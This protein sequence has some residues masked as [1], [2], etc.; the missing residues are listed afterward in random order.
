MQYEEE[1]QSCA[2]CASH[3][4]RESNEKTA[5]SMIQ[6]VIYFNIVTLRSAQRD[7]L[8]AFSSNREVEK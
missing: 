6:I 5:P 2:Q 8:A 3:T 4:K 7:Q 1:K